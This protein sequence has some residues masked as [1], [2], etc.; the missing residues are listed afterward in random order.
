[1]RPAKDDGDKVDGYYLPRGRPEA[2]G[3][4]SARPFD[5]TIR[6]NTMRLR[7]IILLAGTALVVGLWV[8]IGL[9]IS[10]EYDSTLENARG[11]GRNLSAVFARDLNQSLDAMQRAMD[12]IANEMRAM[13]EGF[14]AR[15]SAE[16]WARAVA[17]I[18][19]PGMEGSVLGPDGTMLFTTITQNPGIRD[20]SDRD[21][22]RVHLEGQY[23][24]LY[25]SKP[26]IGKLTRRISIQVSRRVDTDDG[27]FL[28][29]IVFSMAPGALTSLHNTIDLGL[30]G[31][32]AVIGMDGIIRARFTA[33]SQDGA[34]G[35]G[36]SVAMDGWE[37]DIPPD[38]FRSYIRFGV[39]DGTERLFSQR[40]AGFYPLFA[41]VGLDL[42]EVLAQAHED[43]KRVAAIGAIATVLLLPLLVMLSREVGRRG[44]RDIDLGYQRQRL[45]AA[46]AE[47][48]QSMRRAE[49]AN[50]AKS[51]FLAHMSHELR[52]PLHAIIGFSEV[53]HAN[54]PIE[55]AGSP[56]G[57]YAGDILAAGH[58][59]L[60]L[61]NHIL[62]LAK[63]ESGTVRIKETVARIND[64]VRESLVTVR[65]QA[66][67]AGI[68]LR[69]DLTHPSPMVRVDPT[70]IRQILIN[71]LS[72]AVKFTA[73]GGS[74]TVGDAVMSDGSVILRV[75][76]T[77]LGMTEAEIMVA[78]E[79]FGQ[80][81]L[82]ISRPAEGTGLG[83]PLAARL[84]ELHGGRLQVSSMK[85]T[86]TTIEVIIPPERVVATE[87]AVSMAA[88]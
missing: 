25:I 77:G 59:L 83:L 36:G 68:A 8:I 7:R 14:P 87:D 22:F 78:L 39:V 69:T 45:E 44:E 64:L 63:V 55:E 32:M 53:I 24:G 35:V 5:I 70:H 13:P 82:G 12:V 41:T 37:S 72:N 88:C 20:F 80:V 23:A 61:I 34:T 51:R 56:A 76:D 33:D 46:N 11:R 73:R 6:R 27:Q 54:T 79:P 28:G 71:L 18:A 85:G 21:H 31:V 66:E 29:V 19:I 16:N 67:Q 52:T 58:H 47:L 62:D 81:D 42:D 1:M 15:L 84:I 43:A 10:A 49:A 57:Q 17:G 30:H 75:T 2:E 86:G 48:I 3:A 9:S 38:G 26:V 50:Q 40:R 4:R 65:R 74:V 60:E